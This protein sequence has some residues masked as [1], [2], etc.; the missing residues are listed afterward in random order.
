VQVRP[1]TLDDVSGIAAVHV[2]AWRSTYAGQV[3]DDYLAALSVDERAQMWLEIMAD[4]PSPEAGITLVL[5][6]H[7]AVVGF[8]QVGRSRDGDAAPGVGELRA[9]YLAPP[10]WG[11]GHGQRLMADALDQLRAAGFSTAT[12]WVLDTNTRARTFYEAGQWQTDGAVKLDDRRG[13]PLREVRYGR[14]L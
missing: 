10:I 7:T 5:V 3:P 11:L 1:A 2:D 4:D 6:D 13:F 8:A 14:A 12:L 9:I